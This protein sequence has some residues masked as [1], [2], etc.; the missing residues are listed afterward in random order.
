MAE[1]G[2][3]KRAARPVV[4]G[5]IEV[6]RPC[7][8]L[9]GRARQ[10]VVLVRREADPGDDRA[11]LGERIVPAELVV[12]A[13]KIVDAGRDDRALGILPGAVPDAIARVDGAA[14]RIGAQIGAPG[15]AARAHRRCQ[16]LAVPIRAFEPAEVGA[17]AG[18]G[19][20][21]EKGRVGRL[22]LRLYTPAH[23]Q[24]HERSRRHYR[25]THSHVHFSPSHRLF[26]P[27]PGREPCFPARLGKPS[28]NADAVNGRFALTGAFLPPGLIFSSIPLP[29]FASRSSEGNGSKP[30]PLDL[31]LEVAPDAVN[32]LAVARVVA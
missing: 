3:A 26:G 8:T 2:A 12:G 6:R 14:G 19:A 23:A 11:S 30:G 1:H 17:L 27:L 5:Q 18:S 20:G 29:L 32:D 22:L 9:C 13:V 15:L 7:A 4:A 31:V 28:T 24:R 10:R 21:D 25:Q 16:L